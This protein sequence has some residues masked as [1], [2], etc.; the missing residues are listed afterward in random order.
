MIPWRYRP[1][2]G[3]VLLV[4]TMLS[5]VCFLAWGLSTPALD[6]VWTSLISLEIGEDL[7]P[8]SRAR[9]RDALARHPGLVDNVLEDAKY[10]VLGTEVDGLVKGRLAIAVRRSAD[11]KVVLTVQ[12]ARS[13]PGRVRVRAHVGGAHHEVIVAPDAPFVWRLPDEGSFPQ[14]VEIEI[15]RMEGNA[16]A[17]QPGRAGTSVRWSALVQLTEEAP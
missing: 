5:A 8:S 11:P 15:D 1:G 17:S 9:L 4:A 2:A 3:F 14:M 7:P 13:A 10:G 16:P 12:L 6:T